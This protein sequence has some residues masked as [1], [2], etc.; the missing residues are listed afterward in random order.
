MLLGT[1]TGA[2]T[3]P[4]YPTNFMA[5][6]PEFALPPTYR[7]SITSR[8]GAGRKMPM[9]RQRWFI[10]HGADLRWHAALLLWF[11]ETNRAMLLRRTSR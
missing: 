1:W 11:D 3:I 9:Q 5:F 8:E 10:F 4:G 7:K 2:Q 6:D